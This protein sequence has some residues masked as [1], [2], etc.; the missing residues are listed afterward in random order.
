MSNFHAKQ[1]NGRNFP[2]KKALKEAV[3]NGDEVTFMDTSAFGNRGVVA[4]ADLRPGD[5]VV[6]PDPYSRRDWYANVKQTRNGLR[7]V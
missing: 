3:A 1:P 2:T 7:V 5:V 4:A 6:G